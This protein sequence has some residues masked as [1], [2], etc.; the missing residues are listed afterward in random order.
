MEEDAPEHRMAVQVESR[1]LEEH[2]DPGDDRFVF[3]YRVVIQNTGRVAA[4]LLARHWIITDGQGQVEE[5]RGD[6]VVGEQPYLR[7]GESFRY[8]SAAVIQTPV[9]SMHGSY[10][11]RADDGTEF[12]API[13]A[14]TLAMPHTRH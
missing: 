10:R 12:D 2:S 9:G 3:A 4:R 11:M 14:F 13:T 7:P 8:T 5:V 1:Y 6:G